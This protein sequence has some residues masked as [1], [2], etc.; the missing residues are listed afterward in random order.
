MI[1]KNIENIIFKILFIIF[2]AI[3]LIFFSTQANAAFQIF[4]K[5]IGTGKIITL[6]V[7]AN[8]TIQNIKAKIQDKE[9]FAYER[10]SLTFGGTVLEDGRTLSD[11]NIPKN[12]TILMTVSDSSLLNNSLTR[13][14][15]NSNIFI[16]SNFLNSHNDNI[17]L[18]FR[19]N[20]KK[21]SAQ[22]KLLTN[23]IQSNIKFKRISDIDTFNPKTFT[24]GLSNFY[25]N[26]EIG[27]FYSY[28]L[29]NIR[30]D[31]SGSLTKSKANT[32]SFI[33]KDQI[34]KNS[35]I[36]INLGS[37]LGYFKNY[38]YDDSLNNGDRKSNVI[39]SEISIFK[40]YQKKYKNININ[41]NF[42]T[43]NYNLND[44]SENG[45]D[46]KATFNS[47]SF[48][49]NQ[50]LT[51]IKYSHTNKIF[52]MNSNT[53]IGLNYYRN[54]NTSE[55][56]YMYYNSDSSNPTNIEVNPLPTNKIS[57]DLET[58][59]KNNLSIKYIFSLGS[60]NLRSH[61]LN[62]NYSY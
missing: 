62:L 36:L 59:I 26:K 16:Q 13:Q 8:D 45:G 51:G 25:M 30:F 21:N 58:M 53:A 56:Q 4:V 31:N 3:I 41:L 46:N 60:Q 32:F 55:S 47:L 14:L 7:E 20:Y 2:V 11:Y 43:E 54:F 35:F 49:N 17:K 42:K 37:S 50:I 1:L 12:A 44:Y 28:S 27:L 15:V 33:L 24:I 48:L 19:E 22:L 6:D 52:N 10:Q 57:L 18:H 9:G 23:I 5:N 39:F 34:S 29:D 40:K 61:S 38:R